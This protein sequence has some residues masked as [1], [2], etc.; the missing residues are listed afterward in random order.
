MAANERRGN[1]IMAMTH[2]LVV[3]LI[4]MLVSAQVAT[5][6][7]KAYILSNSWT[8]ELD[9]Y[10]PREYFDRLSVLLK[11]RLAV[12]EIELPT[13][14]VD[15]TNL[16]NTDAWV[17]QQVA[18]KSPSTNVL[19]V[20]MDH[21]LKTPTISLNRLLFKNGKETSKLIFTISVYNR[22]GVRLGSDTIVNRGCIVSQVSKQQ[23]VVSF[24]NSYKNFISDMN[25]HLAFI[26]KTLLLKE[27]KDKK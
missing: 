19:F 25:C 7:T 2:R 23:G 16:R 11:E 13:G 27:I 24:Y 8:S 15:T 22:D 12:K 26:R 21:Y 4:A 17:K 20:V 6:Q 9:N 3:A 10:N 1:L 14:K 5:A 18:V